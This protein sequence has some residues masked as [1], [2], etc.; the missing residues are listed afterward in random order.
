MNGI[1]TKNAENSPKWQMVFWGALL[2][3]L[4]LLLL[5][6]GGLQA[7]QT[8]TLITALPFAVIMLL[9]CVSLMKGLAID[10]KYYDRNFSVATVP[11]SG[12]F[13]QERL[14]KIVSFKDSKTVDIY[15]KTTVKEAFEE[16]CKEFEQNGIEARINTAEQPVKI[17]IEI[18][19][20]VI[21]NFIY[22]VKNQPKMVS[23]FMIQEENLPDLD[24]SK[25]FYPKAYFGDSRE[26][27][28]VQYFTKTN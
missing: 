10:Q 8:M 27:Y 6:A 11:W 28:D 4:A 5:N 24:Q 20:D 17:E 16:L 1:A 15:L 19:H 13:W 25:T 3:L 12:E 14:K 9:F 2:A 7:L 18:K 21:N 26:G 23:E 22:G